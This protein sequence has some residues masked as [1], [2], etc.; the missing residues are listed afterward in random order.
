MS[1]LGVGDWVFLGIWDLGFGISR[2]QRCVNRGTRVLA[3][4]LSQ[5]RPY[6]ATHGTVKLIKRRSDQY[7]ALEAP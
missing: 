4:V 2:V 1:N 3:I 5:S 7:P 6:F